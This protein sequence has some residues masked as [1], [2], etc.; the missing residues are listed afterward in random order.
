M[1]LI[2]IIN[3]PIARILFMKYIQLG[4]RTDSDAMIRLKC[5]MLCNSLLENTKLLRQTE[6]VDNLIE[7]CPSYQWELKLKQNF[8]LHNKSHNKDIKPMLTFLKRESIIELEI[9]HEYHRFITDISSKSNIIKMILK[10]IYH[11]NNNT[12]P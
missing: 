8:S 5:Y 2:G 6:I 11:E 4:Q 3:D 9:H 12:L 7:L 1:T 10:N